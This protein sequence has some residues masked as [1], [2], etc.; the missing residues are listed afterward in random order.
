MVKSDSEAQMLMMDHAIE[1][2]IKEVERRGW[3]PPLT[4]K[5]LQESGGSGLIGENNSGAGNSGTMPGSHSL[6]DIR[7]SVQQNY[8]R[9][10]P[11]TVTEG[12]GSLA[13][14]AEEEENLSS[15]PENST[16]L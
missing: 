3:Q 15:V 9:D 1:E 13:E 11:P 14:A 10:S 7:A 2:A 12:D 4:G 6:A 16:T 5:M 8:K